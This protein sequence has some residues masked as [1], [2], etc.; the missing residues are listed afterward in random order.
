MRLAY[1]C[2]IVTPH[3]KPFISVVFSSS[4]VTLMKSSVLGLVSVGAMVKGNVP[5]G[6]RCTGQSTGQEDYDIKHNAADAL[7]KFLR[8]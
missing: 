5:A 7:L 8:D 2:N 4:A 1:N 6:F 3:S